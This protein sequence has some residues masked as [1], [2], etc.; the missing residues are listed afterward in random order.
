MTA[1]LTDFV[2]AQAMLWSMGESNVPDIRGIS[3]L[4]SNISALNAP[5]KSL[6]KCRGEVSSIT[7]TK[8]SLSD[9]TL[10]LQL[11]LV[12]IGSILESGTCLVT[13]E[14]NSQPPIRISKEESCILKNAFGKSSDTSQL[15]FFTWTIPILNKESIKCPKEDCYLRW[16]SNTQSKHYENCIDVNLQIASNKREQDMQSRISSLKKRQSK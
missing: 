3:N 7:K 13:L 4:S 5:M 10:T 15:S 2:N 8:L 9:D 14:S 16:Q 11:Q 1:S 6:N 12:A